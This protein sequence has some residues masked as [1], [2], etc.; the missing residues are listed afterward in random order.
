[1]DTVLVAV[2]GGG[3]MA[4]VAAALAGR[5]RVIA[6][7]PER[8]PTLHA[9]LAAGGAGGRRVGGIAADSLG[10]SRIGVGLL[11]DGQGDRDELGAGAGRG[12]RPG[13]RPAVAELRVLAEYGGA[14]ALAALIT[15]A[16]LPEPGERV[17]AVVC[18][19]NTDPAAVLSRPAPDPGRPA[20]TA[21]G[22]AV[23]AHGAAARAG[24]VSGCGC[25]RR[26]RPE[27]DKQRHAAH[28]GHP[29]RGTEE[30]DRALLGLA[31]QPLGA[32]PLG[33]L[34]ER[35][36]PAACGWPRS[37]AGSGRGP[38]DASRAAP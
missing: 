32:D 10:A 21:G 14:A 12:D 33:E 7:E 9:A 1:M 16:Y 17:A 19:G 23:R 22:A 8:C 2:G 35:R 4:G 18:G 30:L 5:A 28:H 20:A 3:L 6:V 24:G 13:P 15:G 31:G 38:G 25:A 37:R 27:R 26:G 29:G 11:G 36:R 34:V